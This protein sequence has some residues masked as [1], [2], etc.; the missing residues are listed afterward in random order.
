MPDTPNAD[1]PARRGR[2]PAG[3]GD[4]TLGL[5]PEIAEHVPETNLCDGAEGCR[6]AVRVQVRRGVDL[7]KIM[8]TGGVN[9]RRFI[10]G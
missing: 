1:T 9:C 3:H 7:I 2:S 10:P 6:R 8:T 4:S 5:S